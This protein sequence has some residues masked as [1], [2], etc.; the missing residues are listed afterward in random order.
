MTGTSAWARRTVGSWPASPWRPGRGRRRRGAARRSETVPGHAAGASIPPTSTARPVG[1]AEPRGGGRAAARLRAEPA[2][3]RRLR[4]RS[5]HAE[6][7][8]PL[9]GRH[10]SAARRAVV[11]PEDA[12]GHQQ[13]RGPH[14]RQPDADRPHDRQAGQGDRGRRPVQHV[15]HAR[16]QVGD[17][18]RRGAQAARLPRPA[19]DG[20]AV[21]A[22]RARVRR[23]QPRRLLDRRPLRDLHLRVPGQ[24]GQDRPRRPQ[25]ARLS[26]ALARAACRRTSALR[27]T[28]RPSTS[29]T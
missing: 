12:V 3:E 5:R 6:G 9:Q 27:P 15:L 21:L 25:G 16:R 11:G 29:P 23:H 4:D 13:R 19:D 28:A 1:Q 18:R 10:Q 7:G 8:R 14:R 2:V 24:P 17:R 22:R 26:Q 20:A